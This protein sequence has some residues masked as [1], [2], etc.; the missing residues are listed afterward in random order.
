MRAGAGVVPAEGRGRAAPAAPGPFAD[1]AFVGAYEDW[2]ATPYG[3]VVDRIERGLLRELLAP[4]GPGSSVLEIG[5]GTA[6][7]AAALAA[8]GFRA[9]G[10][11]PEP[12]ML[13]VAR[14][15]VPVACAD[16]RRLP[17][18]D[19]AFDGAALVCVLEFVDDPVTL[20]LEARRVARERVAVLALNARSWLGLRR[21]IAGWMG[22]PVFSRARYRG[23]GRLLEAVRA[24]GGDASGDATGAAGATGGA[25]GDAGGEVLRMRSALLLPPA[26]AGRWPRLEEALSRGDRAG[27]GII[28]LALEGGGRGAAG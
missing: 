18:R 10:T 22:H 7:F 9:A 8:D 13:A 2:Y 3:A 19:G 20:L 1:P 27:G 24:A 16:G 28:G 17:F 14:G 6:H 11:D 26:L 12:A 15:R 5:C 23:R 21:R 25:G 4:L